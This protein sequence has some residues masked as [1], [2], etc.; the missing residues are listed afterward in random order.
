M[1][2]SLKFE[3]GWVD[4][5]ENQCLKRSGKSRGNGGS[6]EVL[7]EKSEVSSVFG[8]ILTLRTTGDNSGKEKWA[9]V[10]KTHTNGFSFHPI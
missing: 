10:N 8:F 9:K 4:G 3:L 5:E 2:W 6:K 7:G 1:N